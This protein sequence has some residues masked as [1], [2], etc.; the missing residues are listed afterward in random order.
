MGLSEDLER[1]ALQ[2][3]ELVLPRL[4]AAMAWELGSKLRTM[5][6]DRGL[7]V[8]I[9]VRRFGQPLFYSAMDETNVQSEIDRY[10]AWPAQALGYKMGQLKIRQMRTKATQELGPKFDV[11]EF[12]DVVLGQ[13]A[14][15]LD[16]LDKV[17]NDWI[18]EK[19]SS[20]VS[21]QSPK[22]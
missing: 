8:V 7:P 4:D 21:H 10:I 11:R 5:A 1:I 19:K 2:E 6:A 17:V 18:A 12:H 22:K 14:V 16:V 9:D 13:G 15:P 3:K 20:V